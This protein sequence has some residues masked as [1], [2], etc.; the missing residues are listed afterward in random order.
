MKNRIL[1]MF[2]DDEEV[3]ATFG[4]ARLVRAG[5]RVI[6]RGGSM[7]DRTEALEWLAIFHPE[8]VPVLER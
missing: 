1:D 7:A 8:V 5:D 4:E 6:L 2:T 3:M